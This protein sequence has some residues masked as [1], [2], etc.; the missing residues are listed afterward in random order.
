M[1]LEPHPF[2]GCL[3][4]TIFQFDQ[5]TTKTKQ[6]SDM[7]ISF[8]SLFLSL[9]AGTAFV[10]PV[11]AQFDEN[12]RIN[13]NGNG[14]GNSNGNNGN[15][16]NGN[17]NGRA[18]VQGAADCLAMYNPG[19][20]RKMETIAASVSAGT[21]DVAEEVKVLKNLMK[22]AKPVNPNKK[23][24]KDKAFEILEKNKGQDKDQKTLLLEVVDALDSADLKTWILNGIETGVSELEDGVVMEPR[25]GELEDSVAA[26]PVGGR[27][28]LGVPYK[29]NG[30]LWPNKIVK[31]MVVAENDLSGWW[32][33][34]N[35]ILPAMNILEGLTGLDF[36]YRG[37][38]WTGR[39]ENK[40]IF[41]LAPALQC[42][43]L[44]SDFF[45]FC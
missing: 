22:E 18:N 5:P 41:I 28:R 8:N 25:A 9:L 12:L 23:N 37:Y 39:L 4:K 32:T 31:F 7:K 43:R 42:L 33:Y 1:F 11:A 38:V 26:P 34:T 16:N 21:L 44:T 13:G 15:G 10:H 30:A 27:R 20:C 24:F 6:K 40:K 17:G 2:R 3:T 14:N 45:L 29:G 19:I 36:E 35:H